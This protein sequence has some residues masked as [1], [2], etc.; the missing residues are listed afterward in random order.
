MSEHSQLEHAAPAVDTPFDE[1]DQTLFKRRSTAEEEV[2]TDERI[3]DSEDDKKVLGLKQK[4]FRM[5]THLALWM[6]FT[7]FLVAAIV[8]NENGPISVLSVFYGFFTM[9]LIVQYAPEG[10]FSR[11]AFAVWSAGADVIE[12][13]PLKVR[14][15]VGYGI[16]PV[17]LILTAVVRGDNESGTRVQRVISLCG[18][19]I[20]TLALYATSRN[21]KMIHWP[22]VASG[23]GLQFLLGLF[24]IRT[25]I[26]ETI[27]SYIG[28]FMATFLG[29]SSNGISFII[30]DTMMGLYGSS[31]LFGVLPA[32]IF[33]GA[34]IQVLYYWNVI[35]TAI[36][37]MGKIIVYLF[38]VSGVEVVAACA[39][40]FVGMSESAMLVGPYLEHATNAEIHQ[41]MTSGFATISGSVYLGL[42]GFGASPTHLITC[43]IMSVPCAIVTSKIRYPE[44]EVPLTRGKAIKLERPD[45][46][47]SFVHALANGSILGM[48]LCIVIAAVLIGFLSLLGCGNY[49]LNWVFLFLGV[50]DIT[51]QRLLGYFFYPFAWILGI[52]SQDVYEASKMMG[53]KF[54][55]NEFV[56]FAGAQADGFFTS[57]YTA[58][59][60]LLATFA[61]CSF[62]NPSSLGSQISLLGKM[63]PTRAGDI[64]RVSVSAVIAGALSTIMSACIAGVVM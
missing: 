14:Q 7:A 45:A 8:L 33:F 43:C 4:H 12:R 24:V 36:S 52:P 42:V 64:A 60:Q 41:V 16:F 27:F 19:L 50:T 48:Q 46:E 6:C 18:L 28:G 47:D 3:V 17:A 59:A 23:I 30:G 26:G 61:C 53:V 51:I 32:I 56:G 11:A 2:M 35:Q 40:P 9:F 34:V 44:E 29:F 38:Q 1:K 5:L 37:S 49:V 15:V 22:T 20:F 55:L 62:A 54:A 57:A 10:I 25:Y 58:R 13:I 39:A 31:F 63:A 21:R